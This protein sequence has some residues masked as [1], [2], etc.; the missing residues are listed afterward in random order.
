MLSSKKNYYYYY[1]YYNYST[2]INHVIFFP[3]AIGLPFYRNY[4]IWSAGKSS[5]T[6]GKKNGTPS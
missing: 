1:Y 3:M 6:N 2:E 5:G 4:L